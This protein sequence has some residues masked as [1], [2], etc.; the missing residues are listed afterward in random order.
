MLAWG[1]APSG[2]VAIWDGSDVGTL[3]GHPSAVNRV[4]WAPDG[5]RLAS[6][7]E[8][9]TVCIWEPLAVVNKPSAPQERHNDTLTVAAWS[10]DGSRFASGA[11]DN[12]VMVWDALGGEC[13]GRFTGWQSSE[14]FGYAEFV[15]TVS[16]SPDGRQIAIGGTS[17]G[18]HRTLRLWQPDTE[19]SLVLR[20]DNVSVDAVAWSDDGETLF[21]HDDSDVVQAWRVT[22]EG[23]SWRASLERAV[24]PDDFREPVSWPSPRRSRSTDGTVEALADGRAVR[25]VIGGTREASAA[26]FCLSPVLVAHLSEDGGTLRVADT[27][28]A[29]GNRPVPYLFEVCNVEAAGTA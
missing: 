25:L 8:D 12:E 5:Q 10:P 26:A 6:A 18:D 16:W 11:R 2:E 22:G 7:G 3:V 14:T 27:G 20:E 4:A 9:G 19:E 24:H 21:S 13:I 29:T 17:E 28:A 15:R 23:G 1:G